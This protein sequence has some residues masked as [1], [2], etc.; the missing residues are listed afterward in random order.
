MQYQWGRLIAS[1]TYLTSTCPEGHV[2]L[3]SSS[4]SKHDMVV[5]VSTVMRWRIAL[6][7]RWFS[8]QR[9]NR[10]QVKYWW[11]HTYIWKLSFIHC[12]TLVGDFDNPLRQSLQITSRKHERETT[13][14]QSTTKLS[15][16][17]FGR[18]IYLVLYIFHI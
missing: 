5:D 17:Y 14:L 2:D 8:W 18:Q 9:W 4:V 13:D 15:F 6:T 12:H 10:W 16:F 11:L 1:M 3:H 7:L